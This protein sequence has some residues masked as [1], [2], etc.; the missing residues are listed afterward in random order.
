[1]S[2]KKS[3]PANNRT[4][5]GRRS[6]TRGR[7]SKKQ[8]PEDAESAVC[9]E[10]GGEN[11]ADEKDEVESMEEG[12]ANSASIATGWHVA[13]STLE[14]WEELVENLGGTKHQETRRLIRM[15]QGEGGGAP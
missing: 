8:E 2:K 15:L 14:E 6:T 1:M 3:T 4:P 12:G 10:V 7:S 5:G 11:G 13:C 9:E